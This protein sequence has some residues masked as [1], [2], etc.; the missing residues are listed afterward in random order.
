[1]NKRKNKK[2]KLR[3]TGLLTA[4]ERVEI[5][6]ATS[7]KVVFDTNGDAHYEYQL[8]PEKKVTDDDTGTQSK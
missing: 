5:Q 6:N 4:K 1:M 7:P 8:L 2:L 3:R